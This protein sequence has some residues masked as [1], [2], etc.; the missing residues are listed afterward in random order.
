[1]I[2]FKTLK[3]IQISIL[4]DI[5]LVRGFKYSVKLKSIFLFLAG[6]RNGIITIDMVDLVEYKAKHLKYIFFKNKLS[7]DKVQ[8]FLPGLN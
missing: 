3:H 6:I 5:Y 2:L 4:V 8:P 7:G 1:M